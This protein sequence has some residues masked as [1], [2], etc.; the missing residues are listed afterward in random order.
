MGMGFQSMSEFNTPS[1]FQNLVSQGQTTNGLFALKLTSPGGELN[2]G[3]LN[4]TLYTGTPTYSPIIKE[5]YWSLQL[6]AIKV[7]KDTVVKNRGAILDS[8][9]LEYLYM[10]IR[11]MLINPNRL[12]LSSKAQWRTW[13][14]STLRS[15]GPNCWTTRQ[16]KTP[17]TIIPSLAGHGD[18]LT[19]LSLLEARNFAYLAPVSS[20]GRMKMD[21]AAMAIL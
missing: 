20:V 2:I 4:P 14:I 1:V 10:A 17:L 12:T 15:P 13:R 11:S 18:F 16:V 6:D 3:G 21:R 7:G 19:S 5:G 8:V 9:G